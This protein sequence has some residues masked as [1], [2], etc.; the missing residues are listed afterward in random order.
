MDS[1]TILLR[2]SNSVAE[3]GLKESE[4]RFAGRLQLVTARRVVA[5]LVSTNNN[6]KLSA[7][8]RIKPKKKQ[9]EN[10]VVSEKDVCALGFY[11]YV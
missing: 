6:A 10:Y 3:K 7:S 9:T 8:F 2:N 4:G 11:I 5:W 1:Q